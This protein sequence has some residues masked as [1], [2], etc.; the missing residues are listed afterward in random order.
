MTQIKRSA[1]GL[2][3]AA[4]EDVRLGKRLDTFEDNDSQPIRQYR[5]RRKLACGRRTLGP[6]ERAAILACRERGLLII[7]GGRS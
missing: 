1:A 5:P 4:F 2:Q 3:S 6:G 7:R